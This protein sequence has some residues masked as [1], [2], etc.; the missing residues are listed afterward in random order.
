M[1]LDMC[2]NRMPRYKEVTAS[3]VS[4]IENLFDYERIIKEIVY[5]SAVFTLL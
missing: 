1:G 3:Q 5:R 4:A 2:L